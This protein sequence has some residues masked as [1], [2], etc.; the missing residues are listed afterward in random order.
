VKERVEPVS[1][2][3]SAAEGNQEAK[4]GATDGEQDGAALRAEFGEVFFVKALNQAAM[5]V[6]GTHYSGPVKN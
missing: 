3:Q 4:R 5:V 2:A 1:E 6:K